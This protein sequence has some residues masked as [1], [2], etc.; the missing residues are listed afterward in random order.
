MAIDN[1][2]LVQFAAIAKAMGVSCGDV[3]AAAVTGKA[4][5]RAELVQGILTWLNVLPDSTSCC[6]SKPHS[7]AETS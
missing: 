3:L 6:A 5:N 2:M 7:R 4:G 1:L